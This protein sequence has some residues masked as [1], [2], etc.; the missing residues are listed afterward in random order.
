MVAAQIVLRKKCECAPWFAPTTR[1][2]RP[3]RSGDLVCD[4]RVF[5]CGVEG[6]VLYVMHFPEVVERRLAGTLHPGDDRPRSE[7]RCW[8]VGPYPLLSI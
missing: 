1:V 8:F 5:G 2:R 4:M 6:I 3:L 7:R